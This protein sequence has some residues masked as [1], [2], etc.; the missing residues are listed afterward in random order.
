M[1]F[2]MASYIIGEKK[3]YEKGTE[4]GVI[5]LEGQLIATDDGNGN[6]TLTEVT[7]G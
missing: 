4:S 7:N 2:D 5:V 3:G 1:S 6:I